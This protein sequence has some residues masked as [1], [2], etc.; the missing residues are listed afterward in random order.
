MA[1][2]IVLLPQPIHTRQGIQIEA[3]VYYYE[4]FQFVK[5]VSDKFEKNDALA[6]KKK[7]II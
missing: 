7:R 3:A 4:H 1:P 6:I 5:T 2:N